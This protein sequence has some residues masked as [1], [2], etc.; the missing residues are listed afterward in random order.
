MATLPLPCTLPI[1]AERAGGTEVGSRR[2][3]P[4]CIVR[5]R[6]PAAAAGQRNR[7]LPRSPDA[8][9]VADDNAVGLPEH[10][11]GVGDALGCAVGSDELVLV[12]DVWGT[13]R[14]SLESPSLL[15][16]TLP[17]SPD[18]RWLVDGGFITG[19]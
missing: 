5:G 1:R 11:A 16:A 7:F 18:T 10:G 9:E 2:T 12:R 6:G 13:P 4:Q 19:A 17:E 14:T 8:V 15:P 3:S